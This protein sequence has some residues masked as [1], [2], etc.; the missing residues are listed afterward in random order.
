VVGAQRPGEAQLRTEAVRI[1]GRTD[2][3]LQS[4]TSPHRTRGPRLRSR[5]MSP[6]LQRDALLDVP[7]T[8]PGPSSHSLLAPTECRLPDRTFWRL[9]HTGPEYFKT[10]FSRDNRSSAVVSRRDHEQAGLGRGRADQRIR[11]RGWFGVLAKTC[12]LMRSPTSWRT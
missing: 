5:S 9:K 8:S 4:T 7:R 12:G 3:F 11:R 10:A 2:A 6:E 1:A